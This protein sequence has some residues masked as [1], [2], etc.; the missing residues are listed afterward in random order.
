MIRRCWA[1]RDGSGWHIASVEVG[2]GECESRLAAAQHVALGRGDAGV[3]II[4]RAR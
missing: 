3:P 1:V 2:A 4:W